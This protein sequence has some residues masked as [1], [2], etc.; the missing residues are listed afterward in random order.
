MAKTKNQNREILCFFREIERGYLVNE[1]NA[2]F[3]VLVSVEVLEL[4]VLQL[5]DYCPHFSSND[6]MLTMT[7]QSGKYLNCC[8]DMMISDDELFLKIDVVAK[9]TVAISRGEI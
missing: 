3:G 9:V 6:R 1:N 8:H 7:L 2:F 5:R 4:L